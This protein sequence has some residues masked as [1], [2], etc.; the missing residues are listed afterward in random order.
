MANMIESIALDKLIAHPGNANRMSKSNFAKLVAHIKRSG[1]Y[2]PIVVRPHPGR[3]GSFEIINGHH[4]IEALK[5]LGKKDADCVVWDVD[6]EQADIL[7]ATLNRLAGKDDVHK[8]SAIYEQLSKRFSSKQLSR[9]LPETKTQIERLVNLHRGS[10]TADIPTTQTFANT[11]VF[12]LDDE[13]EQVIERALESA[14]GDINEAGRAKRR[15]KG[16]VKIAQAY[17]RSA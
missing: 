9:L 16:L 7:L 15:A 6:D 17:V 10:Y 5:Q 11:K 2:E 8:K 1:R 14:M 13:Q 4:R 3:T 12:F